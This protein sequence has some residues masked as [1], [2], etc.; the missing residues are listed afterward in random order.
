MIKF[1]PIR[2]SGKIGEFFLLAKIF[3]YT[4]AIYTACSLTV[5]N[6][7]LCAEVEPKH[8]GHVERGASLDV[9]DVGVS[10]RLNEQLHAEGPVR[11]VGSVVEGGLA[12]VVEGVQRDAVLEQDVDHHVLA[13]I[14][15]NVERGA[16]I[17]VDGIRLQK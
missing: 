8:G 5:A 13:I 4:V 16:T 7:S 12:P 10:P 17:G 9:L 11:E 3:T 6:E 1:S 14:A 2:A 15:G